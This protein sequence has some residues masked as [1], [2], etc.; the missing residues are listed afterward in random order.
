MKKLYLI[1]LLLSAVGAWAAFDVGV[2]DVFLDGGVAS[3]PDTVWYIFNVDGVDIDSVAC[4][5]TYYRYDTVFSRTDAGS[6][7]VV[8]G[9]ARFSSGTQGYLCYDPI[10]INEQWALQSDLTTAKDSIFAIIDS[11]QNQDDWGATLAN[12]IIIIDSL[13]AVLDSIQLYLNATI[14]SRASHSAADVYTEFTSGS[15]EDQ[16]KAT[17][18]STFDPTTDVVTPTDTSEGGGAIGSTGQ[19]TTAI[20]A[21]ITN[22]P[23]IVKADVSSLALE[24]SVTKALDSLRKIIDSVEAL[25]GYSTDIMD[26]LYRYVDSIDALVS[27]AGGTATISDADMTAIID[28]MFNRLVSDTVSGSYLATLLTTAGS[29]SGGGA[30]TVNVYVLDSSDSNS[31]ITDAPVFVNN[32]AQ[33]MSNPYFALTD[34]NG[35]ATFNLDAADWA[36]LTNKAGYNSLC[37]TLTVTTTVT[38]SLL[39]YSSAANKTPIF[40]V[41]QKADGTPYDEAQICFELISYPVDSILTYNDIVITQTY[42]YDTADANGYWTTYIYANDTLSDSSYY[43]VTFKD[44]NGVSIWRESKYFVHV[45]VSDT[46][47]NWMNLTKKRNE[48][49]AW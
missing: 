33:S 12:Q 41:L 38:C 26:T 45:P 23:T 4:Y 40:G 14:S 20:K 3:T 10:P 8:Y 5:P 1:I 34:N 32:T 43:K 21:M 46:A 17:G 49:G 22:N 30:Y 6:T 48:D 29:L 47:I 16:F 31:P 25:S 28:S 37:D 24:T 15:N 39:V 11:L 9:R 44:K 27:S 7:M 19:D 18:F 35:L 42:I 2:G 13:Y 36:L